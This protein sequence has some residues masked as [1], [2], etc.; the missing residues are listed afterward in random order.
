MNLKVL[1]NWRYYVMFTLLTVGL[2]FSFA[3]A[4]GEPV[5]PMTFAAEMWLRFKLAVVAASSW[6]AL[7]WCVKY[8]EA[9]G[10]IPEFTNIEDESEDLWD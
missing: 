3:A 4:G 6:Y 1:R 5:V 10:L 7:Y 2:L 9:R 8:W